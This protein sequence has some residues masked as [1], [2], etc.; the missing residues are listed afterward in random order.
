MHIKF[1]FKDGLYNIETEFEEQESEDFAILLYE[2]LAGKF[3]KEI[4]ISLKANHPNETERVFRAYN[5][6]VN[7]QKTVTAAVQEDAL[8]DKVVIPPSEFLRMNEVKK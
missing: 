6:L 8:Q 1:E 4:E 3:T 2:V 7:L 5:E